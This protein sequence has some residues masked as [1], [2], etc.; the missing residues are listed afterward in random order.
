MDAEE[1]LSCAKEKLES[2]DS[3]VEMQDTYS[4]ESYVEG[5]SRYTVPQ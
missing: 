2:D 5:Y 1:R 4:S 3:V